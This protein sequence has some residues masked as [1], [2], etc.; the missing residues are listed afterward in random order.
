[1]SGFDSDSSFFAGEDSNYFVVEA[2]EKDVLGS[3]LSDKRPIDPDEEIF[4]NKDGSIRQVNRTDYSR[5]P[6]KNKGNNP[7]ADN[8]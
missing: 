5:G 4:R 7:W 3:I 8:Q 1:M 6:K 2:V